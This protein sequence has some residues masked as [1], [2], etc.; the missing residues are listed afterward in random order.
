MEGAQ[1]VTLLG[2]YLLLSEDVAHWDTPPPPCTPPGLPQH[3][4][5]PSAIQHGHQ[6][7]KA[8]L[9]CVQEELDPE[10][11]LLKQAEG[12]RERVSGVGNQTTKI[13]VQ[14]AKGRG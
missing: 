8:G 11:I 4:V 7:V 9:R 2:L 14:G 1:V 10:E 12:K 3:L 13:S 6:L 5:Q